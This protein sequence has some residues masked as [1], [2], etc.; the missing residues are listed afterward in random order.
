M[1]APQEDANQARSPGG[2]SGMD[3]KCF[4]HQRGHVLARR[5]TTVRIAI[6]EGSG[7]LLLE[8]LQ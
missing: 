3:L 7:A 4:L 6:L 8:A 1:T 2:M 5:T